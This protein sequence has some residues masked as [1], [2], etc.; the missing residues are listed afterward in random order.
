MGESREAHTPAGG[1]PV[2]VGNRTAHDREGVACPVAVP[3][4]R[5]PATE[6]TG[7]TE[8][9]ERA[10]EAEDAPARAVKVR[11]V[12]MPQRESPAEDLGAAEPA[13]AIAM[14]GGAVDGLCAVEVAE[15]LSGGEIAALCKGDG[16]PFLRAH[17]QSH[18]YQKFENEQEGRQK[19]LQDL[20]KREQM[21]ALMQSGEWVLEVSLK[22]SGSLGH[23]DGEVMWGK[24]S[25]DSEYTAT[26][27]NQLLDC[28]RRAY[29]LSPEGTAAAVKKFGQFC[30]TLRA[31]NITVAFEAV[32]RE[33][34]GDHGQLP[35]L[36]YIVVTAVVDKSQ[37][38]HSR[39]R[40]SRRLIEF[41]IEWGLPLVLRWITPFLLPLT[42]QPF[43]E[44]T[45]PSEQ[46]ER[47]LSLHHYRVVPAVP[48]PHNSTVNIPFI[49]LCNSQ[50]Q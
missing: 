6:G 17:V 1:L 46:V 8:G 37:P 3:T 11:R 43:H 39:F 23:F 26:F 45:S 42:L 47:D 16:S 38:F 10:S 44:E 29:P 15:T 41:C 34:L 19:A 27:E 4:S 20:S 35:R 30:E 14:E 24:N 12:E 2:R 7:K 13:A 25:T 32:C 48:T 33:I 40:D 18:F 9:A 36:N 31:Q 22:H 28:F 21:L 5:V 50:N 49:M